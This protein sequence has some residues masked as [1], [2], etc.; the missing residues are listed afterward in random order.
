M[1][2]MALWLGLAAPLSAQR[3]S[4]LPD[5]SRAFAEELKPIPNGPGV[6]ICEPI[7][8]AGTDATLA[9]FGAGCGEWL[10][11]AMG[12]HPE[13]GQT[14]LW[15]LSDRA[16]EELHVPRLRLSLSQGAGLVRVMGVTH[17]ALGRI[18]GTP[19]RC[20]LTYQLYA[21][22]AQK[23]IGTSLKLVGSETEVI[24]QLPQAART[25]LSGLGVV[26]THVPAS[27]GATPAELTATGHY[28]WYYDQKPTEAEQKQ[29]NALGQRFPLA[30]L[31]SF[32][33]LQG[34]TVQ[35]R[36]EAARHLLEQTSGNF[37][38]FGS[39]ASHSPGS[40]EDF[41]RFMN[42]QAAVFGASNNQALAYWMAPLK[43]GVEDAVRTSQRLVRLGPRSSTVWYLLA[44]AY[45]EQAG[46]IR[47]GQ[48]FDALSAEEAKTVTSLY[49]RWVYAAVQATTLDP[50]YQKA[51]SELAEAATFAGDSERADGAFWKAYA[52]DKSDMNLYMWGLEMYQEKWGG[53]PKTLAKVAHL[54]MVAPFPP[55]ANFYGLSTELREAGF[56]TEAKAM[57][58]RAIV[59]ARARV[60][61]HPKDSEAHTSLGSFMLEQ[62]QYDE[63]E[64]ELKTAIQLEPD[65][66]K[67]H[68]QLGKIYQIYNRWPEAIA[69]YREGVRISTGL[70]HRPE[71]S[72]LS[73][74]ALAEVLSYNT[75][76]GHYEEAVK[77]LR[78]LMK[79][80]PDASRLYTDLGWIMNRQGQPDAAITL[81]STA[82]RL[83]PDS[84]IAHLELGRAY[85]LQSKLDEALREGELAITLEPQNYWALAELA[86]TYSARGDGE[87]GVKMQRQAIATTPGFAQSYFDLGRIYLKMG[88]KAEARAEL[89]RVLT[90]NPSPTLQ[91]S[92]QDLL[93]KNP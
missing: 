25:L 40:T 2:A 76:D 88:K 42:I 26:K 11:W 13:L 47:K 92:T 1:A 58:A 34:V 17:T 72:F 29:I 73:K 50:S 61:L 82:A 70:G 79:L 64:A 71:D 8:A 31:L 81:L 14:P 43:P 86:E 28:P 19:Q 36:E 80:E 16:Q 9:D 48:Y 77:L 57:N 20:A 33:H 4:P 5:L 24:A 67:A 87:A 60:R 62:Q 68:Y 49:P 75:V 12:F 74:M 78:E 23:P 7:A 63:A 51:W 45:G 39:V 38:V 21:L 6:Q 84:A 59:Q 65:S 30:A 32:E 89:Q 90:L 35:A 53:D 69:Q 10:Q 83:T 22:P 44:Q 66:E 18:S 52:L 56:L 55:D 3:R 46:S 85:R 41:I 15:Q 54:T 93:D 91:K 37:L 27:V